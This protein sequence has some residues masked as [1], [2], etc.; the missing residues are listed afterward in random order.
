M[1]FSVEVMQILEFINFS[2]TLM[3]ILDVLNV[4][5]E[6]E[7]AVCKMLNWTGQFF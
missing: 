5:F 2:D 3:I 1:V 6:C 7:R 4:N